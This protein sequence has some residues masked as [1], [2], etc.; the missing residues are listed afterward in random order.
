MGMFNGCKYHANA[1][2]L[3]KFLYTSIFKLS[4]VA[5]DKNVGNIK[6]KND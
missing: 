3:E 6:T 1:M 4:Y 2:G 5:G